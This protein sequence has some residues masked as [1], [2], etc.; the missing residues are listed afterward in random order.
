MSIKKFFD[1]ILCCYK[2]DAHLVIKIFGIKC[3]FKWL[4]INQLEDCCCIPNLEAIRDRVVFVH[5]IGISI[6][7][8]AKIGY[9]CRMYH[10]VTIGN[11]DE[12]GT[13]NVPEIGDNVTIYPNSVIFGKIKIG[14]NVTIG[15]GSIVFKDIPDNAV[16]AGNPAKIIRYKQEAL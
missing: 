5:P 8:G 11:D 2:E 13:N 12:K 9:N 3:R 1:K 15:A 10:N 14:N 6:H 4:A 7:P 16:V